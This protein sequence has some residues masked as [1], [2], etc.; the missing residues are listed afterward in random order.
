MDN[1]EALAKAIIEEMKNNTKQTKGKF[2]AIYAKENY[3]W[4]KTLQRVIE[5]YEGAI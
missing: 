3:S 1:Y 2:A 5:I 4:K